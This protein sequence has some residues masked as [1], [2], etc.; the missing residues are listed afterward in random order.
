MDTMKLL[1]LFNEQ[2]KNGISNCSF[3]NSGN[4]ICGIAMDDDH[5]LAIYDK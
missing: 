4:L 1:C 5:T 2:L 3:S